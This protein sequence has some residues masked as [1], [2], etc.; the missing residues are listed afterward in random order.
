MAPW[1]GFPRSGGVAPVGHALGYEWEDK[2]MLSARLAIITGAVASALLLSSCAAPSPDKP[3]EMSAGQAPTFAAP[4]ESPVAAAVPSRP[5]TPGLV[6]DNWVTV[7]AEATRIP[8]RALRAY[9][10]AALAKAA[11]M[12]E[13]GV[14][15]NTIAAIGST[16]SDHGRHDGSSVDD[17][18]T[19]SPPI[20][21]V[22]LDGDGNIL[23][24][25]SDAGA[26]DGDATYDRAIGPMQFIPQS[27]NNWNVDAN[28]DGVADP[29]NLDDA[30]MA[31]ANYLCR[32]SGD[33][34]TETG[35]QRAIRGYNPN[36]EYVA[37]VAR[38]GTLYA[39]R[40]AGA[41]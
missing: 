28:A 13:C 29:H 11:Q 21:G 5:G 1:Y 30:A 40:A 8:E 35:W 12:P 26:I 31:T 38:T 10:G 24:R 7:T 22:A 32:V 27:W 41:S 36:D 25:D 19:V 3:T 39:E 6:D 33:L 18:G 20:Y 15:W 17:A 14:G 34:V 23:I 2:R 16:E 9:A 4:A 37:T